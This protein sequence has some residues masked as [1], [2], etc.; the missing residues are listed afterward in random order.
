MTSLSRIAANIGKVTLVCA[1]LA[2]LILSPTLRHSAHV[3]TDH[4]KDHAADHAL[5]H[6]VDH[7]VADATG[8]V[9]HAHVPELDPAG[10]RDAADL[11]FDRLHGHGSDRVDHD[12]ATPFLIGSATQ[13]W[14]MNRSEH[15][16]FAQSHPERKTN[17]PEPPPRC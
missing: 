13:S 10:T 12:H 5:D 1:A 6:A 8:P 9:S 15:R 14:P 3:A 16:Q 4:G 11:L 17:A 7:A 2:M